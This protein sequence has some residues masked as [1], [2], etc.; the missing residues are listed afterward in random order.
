LVD[1]DCPLFAPLRP[2]TRALADELRLYLEANLVDV[3]GKDTDHAIE[4]WH[5]KQSTYPQLSQMAIDYLTIP[6][7]V[8]GY[9]VCFTSLTCCIAATSV[10]VER[11]FSCGQL[12]LPHTRSQ[13]T[14]TSA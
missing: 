11:L 10:D 4:W 6:R 5:E 1:V 12:I 2:T 3:I 14:V 13:L 7:N 9:F 8:V